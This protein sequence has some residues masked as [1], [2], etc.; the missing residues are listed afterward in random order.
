MVG[1]VRGGMA[2]TEFSVVY[3]CEFIFYKISKKK[4]I[5]FLSLSFVCQLL[6]L[7]SSRSEPKAE[8]SISV[9][10]SL[11]GDFPFNLAEQE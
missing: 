7:C 2:T 6:L 9:S 5:F 11:P 1:D 3:H 10:L 8:S 4:R